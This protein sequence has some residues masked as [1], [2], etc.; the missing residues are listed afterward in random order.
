MTI[1][2]Y[3][4]TNLIL[5]YIVKYELSIDKIRNTPMPPTALHTIR[6]KYATEEI[7]KLGE[8]ISYPIDTVK[9]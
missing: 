5:S 9:H 6:E 8:L 1:P 7:D 3:T 4:I 2:K